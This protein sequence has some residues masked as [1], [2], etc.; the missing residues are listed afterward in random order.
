MPRVTKK[1][2]KKTY[3]ERPPLAL[4]EVYNI[5]TSGR[6]AG[7][8]DGVCTTPLCDPAERSCITA[9][10]WSFNTALWSNLLPDVFQA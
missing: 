3:L 7:G 9:N 1:K 2:K 8:G 4:I 10:H 5:E 6:Q